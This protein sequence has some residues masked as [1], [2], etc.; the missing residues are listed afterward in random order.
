V[1]A[2]GADYPCKVR[3]RVFTGAGPANNTQQNNK[4]VITSKTDRTT[5]TCGVWSFQ[6]KQRGLRFSRNPLILFGSGGRIRTYDLWVM[7]TKGMVYRTLLAS[8]LFLR[9]S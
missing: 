6:A 8:G 4:R 2:L 9:I 3:D 1:L 7:R 5:L